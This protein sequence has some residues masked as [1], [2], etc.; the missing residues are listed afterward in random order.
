MKLFIF[1]IS[2]FFTSVVLADVPAVQPK[3]KPV[4]SKQAMPM[5]GM[6]KKS[7]NRKS[8]LACIQSSTRDLSGET[9]GSLDEKDLTQCST[10]CAPKPSK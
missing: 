5:W 9:R 7:A 3:H 1:T 4:Q 2:V 6:I 8:C 10:A